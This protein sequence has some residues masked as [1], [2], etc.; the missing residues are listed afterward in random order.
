MSLLLA[1][2][3]AARG[4]L[5]LYTTDVSVL[6]AGAEVQSAL[7]MHLSHPLAVKV[8]YLKSG[9]PVKAPADSHPWHPTKQRKLV[10]LSPLKGDAQ[11]TV[12]RRDLRI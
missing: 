2:G 1:D 10:K 3:T 6:C 5:A 4:K 8:C 11:A 12:A 7:W 9:A